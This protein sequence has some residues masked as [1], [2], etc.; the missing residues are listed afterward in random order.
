M[1]NYI[2]LDLSHQIWTM[3]HDHCCIDC[4]RLLH[5][6]ILQQSTT[7]HHCCTLRVGCSA[8]VVARS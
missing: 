3:S 2:T 6:E 5:F 4:C 8:A 1:P 7:D